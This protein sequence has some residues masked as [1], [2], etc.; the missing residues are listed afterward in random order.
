MS[1]IH[2]AY[3]FKPNEFAADVLPFVKALL[4]GTE[5]QQA[6]HKAVIEHFEQ[7]SSGSTLAMEYGGWDIGF[8]YEEAAREEPDSAQ[9]IAR[10]I[11]FL[12]YDHLFP[13]PSE[14]GLSGRWWLMGEIL[15]ALDWHDSDRALP[16][17]GHSFG[18]FAQQWVANSVGI[19]HYQRGDLRY[20][21]HVWPGSTAS[22]IGWLDHTDVE[23]LLDKLKMDQ[24]RLAGMNLQGP[25][26]IAG[27]ADNEAIQAIYQAALR[28]LISASQAQCGVCLITSG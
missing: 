11:L 12:L 20:W 17:H 16:V 2:E 9:D 8:L 14:L 3:L 15:S 4:Q 6:L 22:Q 5:G 23:R 26:M 21:E 19:E 25:G 27:A 1:I 7:R 24:P 28:M 13:V 18:Y 10:W